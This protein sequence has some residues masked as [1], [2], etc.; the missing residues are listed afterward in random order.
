MHRKQPRMLGQVSVLHQRR[1][2]FRNDVPPAGTRCALPWKPSQRAR[3]AGLVFILAAALRTA[4]AAAP[5]SEALFDADAYLAH[6]KYLADDRLEGRQPGTPGIEL[7]A[8]YIARQFETAGLKP[9]GEDNTW[10]QTFEIRRGKKIVES[11]A[12]LDFEGLGQSWQVRRD[13]VPLPFS[14]PEEVEGP[15]AFAGYGIE[16]ELHEYN[17]YAGFDADGKILLIFRFEPRSDD[18]NADFGGREPSVYAEFRTKAVT[19]ARHGARALLIVNPR[20]EG[21]DDALFEFS[22]DLSAQTHDLPMVHVSRALA[23]RLL[24]HAKLGSLDDLQQKLDAER[25]PLSADLGLRVRLRPGIEPNRF[26]TRNVLGLLPG[27]GADDGI[28]VVGAHYDHLGRVPNWRSRDKTPVIHNGADDNASGVAGVIEMARVL[29]REGGVRRS[30]L[31][32]A[33]SGEELGLLGSKHFVEHPTVSLERI[34][35]VVIFDMIGRLSQDKFVIFGIPSALEFE[36]LVRRAAEQAEL[37]YRAASGFTGASDHASF[38]RSNIPY[39]FPMTGV[40]R[41]YHMPEDDWELIDAPGAVRILRMFH[42]IVRELAAMDSGPTFREQPAEVEPEYQQVKPGVEHEREA[43]E[44]DKQVTRAS[45]RS[46]EAAVPAMPRVRL[47][48]TPDIAGDD[49]GGVIAEVVADGGAAK[50]A[51]MQ[52]GDRIVQ[53]GDRKIRDIYG[54]MDAL[55]GFK[56]GDSVEIKVLRKGEELTLKVTFQETPKRRGSE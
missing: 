47:G 41:Q 13:W 54:Y 9:A 42:A 32:I 26:P 18:P 25:K 16:A 20:R 5:D 43:Q 49:Q 52:D 19:A 14:A 30:V 40:H 45:A 50:A 3:I 34:R 46:G 35:A 37:R 21:L 31:F 10:F 48:I 17:D 7:A 27:R 23:Q 29:A 33:F 22:E 11:A 8:E 1:T 55:K 39:L 53:I 12:R 24:E 6:V 4:G 15:L 38:Y 2:P 44:A 28:V 36:E 56:P 51:G